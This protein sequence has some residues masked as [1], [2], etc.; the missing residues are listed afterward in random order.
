MLYALLLLSKESQDGAKFR[1]VVL[2]G[3]HDSTVKIAIE[4]VD[5]CML[6]SSSFTLVKDVLE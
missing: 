2:K 5:A 3:V 4:L 6:M 1:E